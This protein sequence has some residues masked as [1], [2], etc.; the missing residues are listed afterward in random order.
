MGLDVMLTVTPRPGMRRAGSGGWAGT[1]N[2]FYWFDRESDLAAGLYLQTLPFYD[3][4]ALSL[5]D[6]FE[7]ALYA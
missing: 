3:A 1:F 7:R 6:E 5:A 2:T 4:P